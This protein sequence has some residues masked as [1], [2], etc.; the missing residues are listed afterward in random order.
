MNKNDLRKTGMDKH[1]M[2]DAAAVGSA[3]WCG[4]VCTGTLVVGQH[5]KLSTPAAGE[6]E[7]CCHV[8][9]SRVMWCSPSGHVMMQGG[10]DIFFVTSVSF[11]TQTWKSL[12]VCNAEH[13]CH[14][15]QQ[16]INLDSKSNLKLRH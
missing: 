2:K 3:G 4:G 13:S 7:E 8:Q 11:F 15:R 6:K 9:H 5:V 12:L 16:N 1:L 14:C 10:D